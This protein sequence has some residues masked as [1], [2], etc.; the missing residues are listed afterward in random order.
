MKNKHRTFVR[1]AFARNLG[2]IVLAAVIISSI[3]SCA[4][5]EAFSMA[6]QMQNAE[7]AELTE[8]QKLLV[9]KWR[10]DTG[11]LYTFNDDRTG[12]I[13]LSGSNEDQKIRWDTYLD[14]LTIT[15]V[16]SYSRMDTTYTLNGDEL[17]MIPLGATADRQVKTKREL[18]SLAFTHARTGCAVSIGTQTD[19]VIVIPATCPQGHPVTAIVASKYNDSTYKFEGGFAGTDITS[20][21][22]P[23]SITTIGANTFSDCE[24]IE[25]VILLNGV[26]TIGDNAFSSSVIKSITIPASVTS[27]GKAAFNRCYGLSSLTIPASVTSI[28]EAAFS[29]NILT[30]VTFQGTIPAARFHAN[31]LGWNGAEGYMGDLR[32][33]YLAGGPGT[34]TSSNSYGGGTWTK[35]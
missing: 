29:N 8:E 16:D 9:G 25:S 30:S 22:I 6:A 4:M 10:S 11:H 5:L 20:I 21:T 3:F 23:G 13:R 1:R 24:N 2:I 15:M 7:E 28:G 33:K 26:T 31:A 12:T 35:R 14:N 17:I 27:I 19:K 32:E 18:P 34:Y